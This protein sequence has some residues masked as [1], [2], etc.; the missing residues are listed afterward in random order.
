MTVVPLDRTARPLAGDDAPALLPPEAG[1]ASEFAGALLGAFDDASAALGRADAAERAF[2]AH[3]GGLQEMVV[4][5]ARADVTLSLAST[6]ASRAA[7][8]LATILGMQV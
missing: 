8:S 3:R 4:E 7:Q 5:R 1:G 2:A 6:A